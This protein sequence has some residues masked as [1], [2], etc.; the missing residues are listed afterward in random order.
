MLTVADRHGL[1]VLVSRSVDEALKVSDLTAKAAS[2][3][4]PAVGRAAPR[5]CIFP[6]VRRQAHS[7]NQFTGCLLS[8]IVDTLQDAQVRG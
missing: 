4:F 6:A 2:A 1:V 5:V 7:V 3:A 8:L